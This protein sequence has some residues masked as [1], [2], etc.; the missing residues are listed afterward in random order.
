[1]HAKAPKDQTHGL[2]QKYCP[3]TAGTDADASRIPGAW[4]CSWQRRWVRVAG[5]HRPYRYPADAAKMWI[6]RMREYPP[7]LEA[8]GRGHPLGDCGGGRCFAKR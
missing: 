2:D 1:M 4:V 6:V 5:R 7:L 3:D 8:L